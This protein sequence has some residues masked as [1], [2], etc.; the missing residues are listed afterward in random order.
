MAPSAPRSRLTWPQT[1]T[2]TK[3]CR[4]SSPRPKAM[5][6]R[7]AQAEAEGQVWRYT[8][9]GWPKAKPGLALR[10]AERANPAVTAKQLN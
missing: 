10:A 7:E 6:K 4:K 3:R 9:T 5:A 8:V 1:K 2:C